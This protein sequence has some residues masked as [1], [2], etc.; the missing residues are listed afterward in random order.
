MVLVVSLGGA[1][2]GARGGV[3]ARECLRAKWGRQAGVYSDGKEPQISQDMQHCVQE[4]MPNS[5]TNVTQIK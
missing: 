4:A 2:G 1:G 3:G 5:K